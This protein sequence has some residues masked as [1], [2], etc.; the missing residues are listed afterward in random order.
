MY[1]EVLQAVM[2]YLAWNFKD[3]SGESLAES[4]Y[5]AMLMLVQ[6][7]YIQISEVDLLSRLIW[8]IKDHPDV[9]LVQAEE[10]LSH[11]CFGTIPYEILTA[12]EVGH[13]NLNLALQNYHKPLQR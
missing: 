1:E 13:K 2:Q 4:S 12:C 9:T 11:I 6:S 8:W 3:I 5:Q 7:E 10:L